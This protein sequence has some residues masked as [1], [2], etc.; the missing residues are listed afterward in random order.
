MRDKELQKLIDHEAKRQADTIDLTASEN[1]T[2]DDVREA[3][4]SV[5]TNKYAE[6]YV[7]SRYYSGTKFADE[8]EALARHRALALFNLSPKEWHVNVQALSGTAANFAVL[9][10]LVPPGEKVFSLALTMGGH[11]SHG[12]IASAT[13]KIWKQVPYSLDKKTERLDYRTIEANAK[14]HRPKIVIAGFTAYSRDVDWKKFRAI[15]DA[16]SA[17][18][19]ADVSHTAGLIAARQ[20]ASPFP[21]A[22]VVTMTTHKT[23]R[24]PRAALIFSR[25][26]HARAIDRAV[27]PGLQGGPHL[28]A[29]AAVAAAL[30]EASEPKF[31][32]YA[33]Q[34]IANAQAL[35]AELGVLGWRVVS[36]GTDTH[37]FLLDTMSRGLSGAAA[38]E[39]LENSGILVNKNVIPF[40]SRSP[41]DPSGIRIG[42]PAATS[43]GLKERDMKRIA[44]QINETLRAAVP[45]KK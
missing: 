24:G 14:H 33:K 41:Q 45:K 3:L 13:G 44:K 25:M 40:D 5:F 16:A 32:A 37:L 38:A 17:P 30:R 34:I 29:I 36:G 15:A 9:W 21:H 39:A 12:S 19:M 18:L 11:L 22:D 6:G 43:A 8:L 35:A 31:T 10:A 23:L 42:T 1:I 26:Q 7:G 2:S 28:N 20:L 4:G 27:F